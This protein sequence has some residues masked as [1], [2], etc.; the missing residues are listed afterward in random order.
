M[1]VVNRSCV[2][3]LSVFS[4]GGIDIISVSPGAVSSSNNDEVVV[5]VLFLDGGNLL[6]EEENLLVTTDFDDGMKILE[7]EE[8]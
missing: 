2:F 4:T 6:V 1:V 7:Y 8:G 3:L 5:L